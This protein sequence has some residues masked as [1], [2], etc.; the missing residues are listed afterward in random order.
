MNPS[1][2]SQRSRHEST[3][4][5]LQLN[6]ESSNDPDIANF[7]DLVQQVTPTYGPNLPKSQIKATWLSHASFLVE[8]PS[9]D[10]GTTDSAK[11][12]LDT[13]DSAK[14]VKD[15][16][17]GRGI[18]VL[19]DPAFSNRCSPFQSFGGNV[20]FSRM[21]LFIWHHRSGMGY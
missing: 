13:T 4:D 16:E 15:T 9:Q 21:S 20:R 5:S 19:F 11:S 12:D 6:K 1:F 14:D 7:K 3:N 18:R 2:I 8:M 10:L 17:R